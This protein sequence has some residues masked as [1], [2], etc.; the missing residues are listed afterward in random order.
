MSALTCY[1]GLEERFR[2]VTGLRSVVLGEPTGDLDLPGLYTAY[3]GF[4]RTLG[5][6]QM[7][8]MEH[9]FMHRLIIRWQDNAQAEMQLLTLLNAIPASVELDIQ[10]GGRLLQGIARITDGDAGFVTIGGVKY[11][12]VDYTT[13]V[14]EKAPVRSGI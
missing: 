3:I 9:R 4:D 10:L 1:Q 2:T 11:R 5:R 6:D 8:V 7:T 13:L 12:C 14:T